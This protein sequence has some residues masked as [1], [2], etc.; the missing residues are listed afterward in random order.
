MNSLQ[1]NV[2]L[3]HWLARVCGLA[4][5][6]SMSLHA[7]PASGATRYIS[8]V[9][10]VPLRSGPS[11]DHRIV[12]RGLTSGTAMELLETDEA[13]GFS[14]VRIADGTEGWIRNQYLLKEPVARL[15]LASAEDALARAQSELTA[16]RSRIEVLTQ[17]NAEQ[18]TTQ[19]EQQESLTRLQA[20]LDNILEVSA[21]AIETQEA[22]R[23]LTENNLRLQRALDAVAAERNRLEENRHNQMLLIGGGLI[24]LGLLAGVAI[25]ARPQRSAWN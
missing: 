18:T 13:S 23:R 25:K 17:T 21:S 9:L 10:L 22:N 15:K 24:L 20:E 4:F 19:A 11:G 14:L 1:H 8:D 16:A 2:L 3:R 6:L 7:A 5:M 12:H